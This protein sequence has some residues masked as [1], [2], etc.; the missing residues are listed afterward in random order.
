MGIVRA[1]ATFDHAIL[2]GTFCA[3]VAAMLLYSETNIVKRVFW[4]GLCLFRR[5]TVAIVVQSDGVRHY[6]RHIRLRRL[7]QAI[8]P[9]GGG[10]AGLSLRYLSLVGMATTNDPLGWILSHLTLEPESGY[11]RLL[12][13]NTAIYQISFLPGRGMLSLILVTWNCSLLIVFG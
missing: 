11:F 6:V 7:D 9:G 12:E 13:W 3:M 1:T 4:V 10:R 2:F 5:G 8:F